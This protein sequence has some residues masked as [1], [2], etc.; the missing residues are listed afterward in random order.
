MSVSAFGVQGVANKALWV[1]AAVVG[2]YTMWK[3]VYLAPQS[4]V[5]FFLL[6]FSSF[7]HHHHPSSSLLP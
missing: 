5:Y 6:V 1:G 2:Y 3:P 7:D 4:A